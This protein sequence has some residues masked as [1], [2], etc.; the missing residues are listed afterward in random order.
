M[1][2]VCRRSKDMRRLEVGVSIS[3]WTCQTLQK[4]VQSTGAGGDLVCGRRCGE[5]VGCWSRKATQ[6]QGKEQRRRQ[7]E[8]GEEEEEESPMTPRDRGG[9]VLEDGQLPPTEPRLM[10]CRAVRRDWNLDELCKEVGV[11]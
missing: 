1:L 10:R 4:S 6:R 8:E 5:T 11:A 3:C 7:E 9:I 2:C